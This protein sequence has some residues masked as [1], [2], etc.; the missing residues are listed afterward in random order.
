MAKI[1]RFYKNDSGKI[2]YTKQVVKTIV[3]IA[4]QEVEGVSCVGKDAAN[5]FKGVALDFTSEGIK[6]DVF[7]KVLYGFQVMDIAYKIQESVKRNVEV[8]TQYKIASTNVHVLAV[9]FNENSEEENT[10][11]NEHS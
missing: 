2:S 4:A 3:V 11:T 5:K 7:I 6:V 10:N 8:M 1:V 9:T